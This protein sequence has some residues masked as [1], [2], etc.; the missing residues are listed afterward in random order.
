M[1]DFHHLLILRT[2]RSDRLG[3]A[4]KRYTDR[5][6]RLAVEP[7][8]DV[9]IPEVIIFRSHNTYF[10]VALVINEIHCAF[11]HD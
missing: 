1:N 9:S 8:T 7:Q 10:T 2:L 11:F 6:L 3:A 5:H 4:L